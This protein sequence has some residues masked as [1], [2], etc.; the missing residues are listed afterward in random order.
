M[1]I[2]I[3]HQNT[4]IAL[5]KEMG[6]PL[7]RP[8]NDS[9]AFTSGRSLDVEVGLELGRIAAELGRDVI[10]SSWPHAQAK[11]PTGFSIAYRELLTVDVVDGLVP[12]AAND[13]VPV[14]LISVRNAETFSVDTGASSGADPSTLGIGSV[15]TSASSAMS[16]SANPSRIS[17]RPY[18]RCPP[19]QFGI[20]FGSTFLVEWTCSGKVES[21]LEVKGELAD[22]A[23][24]VH[25]GV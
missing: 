20:A 12:Y 14:V 11:R 2:T 5:R 6:W 13:T 25:E 18:Q 9:I 4:M 19:L 17:T 24:T 23:A 10:Y 16:A 21:S 1:D 15:F 22:E 8:A 7:F 3:H